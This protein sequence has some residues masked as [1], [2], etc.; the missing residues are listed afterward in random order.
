[1]VIFVNLK[2]SL[3]NTMI[4]VSEKV[5]LWWAT[6]A[7]LG[8]KGFRRSSPSAAEALGQFVGERLM[9][10]DKK[11]V[12]V[13]FK[14]IHAGRIAAL[15]G[16]RKTGVEILALQDVTPTPHNGCRLSKERRI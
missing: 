10:E 15:R 16:L 11:R 1:M 9:K 6:P 7:V 5:P 2:S 13:R 12:V 4:T 14:G 3:N 8:F